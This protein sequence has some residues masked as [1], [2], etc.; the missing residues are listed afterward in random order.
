[1][2]YCQY[3]GKPAESDSDFCPFCGKALN[4]TLSYGSRIAVSDS[5][6]PFFSKHHLFSYDGRRGRL[7]YIKVCGFW[8]LLL[9]IP[10][11]LLI[12]VIAVI[13][14]YN[15]LIAGIV[16]FILFLVFSYPAICKF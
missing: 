9:V 4:Q 5:K 15:V 12:F 3:C 8:S 10:Y 13:A 14:D 6:E 1:M 2:E 11:L 7:E 16:G